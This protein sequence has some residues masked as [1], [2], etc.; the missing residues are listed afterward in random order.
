M[1][2]MVLSEKSL[3]KKKGFPSLIN[4]SPPSKDIQANYH[5][6]QIM[7][8]KYKAYNAQKKNHTFTACLDSHTKEKHFSYARKKTCLYTTEMKSLT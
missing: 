4:R 8:Y 5:N 1:T 7:N 6:S 3:Q 2:Q